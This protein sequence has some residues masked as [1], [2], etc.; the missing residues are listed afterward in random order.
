MIIERAK[1][2]DYQELKQLWLIVFDEEPTFLEHFF[3]TRISYQD[4]FVARK[5]DKLVSALHALPLNYHKQGEEHPTSYIVGAAT[6][7]EYR[8]QGIM[9]KLLEATRE[10]YDHPITLFPAVRPFYEANG[11]F[12]T[13]SVLSFS[14]PSD[15]NTREKQTTQL[16]YQE[17]DAIYRTA[18]S[19]EGALLRDE[20]AWSFLTDGYE[21]LSVEGGYAFISEGKAVETMVLNN[22]GAS[23]MLS[24]LKGRGITEVRTLESSPLANLIGREK[25]EPIPMGMST[26][27]ELQG[28]YI[29]EQY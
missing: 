22:D 9:G 14:I 2:S 7:K 12:T 29:A 6:Y 18:T 19:E 23:S 5:D 3:A 10:A 28:V 24:L 11:Y 17:L 16:S 4:I 26:S 13:S 25:G 21:V 20:E 27:K 1:P 15:T 8:R